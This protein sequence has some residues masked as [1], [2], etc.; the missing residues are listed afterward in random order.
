MSRPAH[1]IPN[2]QAVRR[3]QLIP[4]VGVVDTEVCVE[5]LDLIRYELVGN[6]P[7]EEEQME[8]KMSHF[9]LT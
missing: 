8:K 2:H 7:L 5:L 9:A 3:L 4:E 6:E 1:L